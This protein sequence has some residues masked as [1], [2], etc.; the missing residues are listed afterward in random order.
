MD[1]SLKQRIIGAIVL[2]ALAIIFLPAILKEKASN[3]EFVSQIPEKPQELKEYVIDTAKIERLNKEKAN[4]KKVLVEEVN[5][6]KENQLSNRPPEL[7]ENEVSGINQSS[8]SSEP[9]E[10]NKLSSKNSN[11]ERKTKKLNAESQSSTSKDG[12][13]VDS[14]WVVQVA[15]F[16]NEQNAKNLVKK[17]KQSSFKAY[18]RK[19]NNSGKTVFRVFVGPYIEKS[20]A[21]K[22]VSDINAISETKSVIRPFDPIDH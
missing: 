22:A 4:I 6:V 15:S 12:K 16:S 18:R 3:G 19:A 8:D 7:I 13:F 21:T 11:T 2:A 9:S 20:G 5:T 14:A 1:N 17:L 10:G